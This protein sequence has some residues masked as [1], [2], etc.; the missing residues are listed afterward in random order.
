MSVFVSFFME[1]NAMDI[2]MIHR[3]DYIVRDSRACGLG[4]N[5]EFKRLDELKLN[6][7]TIGVISTECKVI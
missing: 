2:L 7:S 4:C 5:F 6:F 3:F 1:S